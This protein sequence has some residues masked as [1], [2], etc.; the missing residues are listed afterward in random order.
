[1]AGPDGALW[2]T[3]VVSNSIGRITTAGVVSNYT[4]PGIN[5]PEGITVGPDGALWFTN[6]GNGSIGTI[7]TAGVVSNFT[8]PS[9][10]FPE[11]IV[12]GS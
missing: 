9:I 10:S 1:M 3:N 6:W 7:T 2:F 11:G 4:G 5:D 8:D 12:E